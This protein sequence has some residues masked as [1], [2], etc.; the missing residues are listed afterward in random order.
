MVQWRHALQLKFQ[1][2]ISPDAGE[3]DA[4][5]AKPGWLRPPCAVAGSSVAA[6]EIPTGA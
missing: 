1:K 3:S 4:R 5:Q 6:F 2:L